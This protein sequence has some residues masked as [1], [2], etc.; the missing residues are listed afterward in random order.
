MRPDRR[1]ERA[2]S[3]T[4][5]P[6]KARLL[7][8]EDDSAIRTALSVSLREDG[9]DVR[10]L[11]D[12]RDVRQVTEEFRPDLAI[13]DIRLPLGPNGYEIAQYLRRTSDVAVLF[14]TAADG[15][16][17]RL[18]GFEAGGD[19]YMVKPFSMA[20]LLA[21]VH[22]LLR[23]SGRL[24]HAVW[25]VGDLVVDEGART[26]V[27]SGVRLELTRMEEALLAVLAQHPG[28]VFS[29]AQLLTQVWGFDSYDVN[30]VE[31]HISAL[32]RKLEAHGPRLLHTVRGAGYVLRA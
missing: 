1:A 15:L 21:R 23:R 27:R 29:K 20:E 31:V 9:I 13:L 19:D 12:G 25:E 30:V 24:S 32:R 2:S 26:V 4:P 3:S 10:A 8:V 17:S 7:V 22:A 5:N 28:Q 18:A 14:L 6:R 16:D 11:T